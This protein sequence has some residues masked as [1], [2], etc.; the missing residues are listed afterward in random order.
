MGWHATVQAD[1]VN[2]A[3]A[4][5]VT[6][7]PATTVRWVAVVRTAEVSEQAAPC[8]PPGADLG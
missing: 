8:G 5:L 2:G 6:G 3:L 7:A 4:I 1:D